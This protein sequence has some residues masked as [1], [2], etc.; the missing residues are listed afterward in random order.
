MAHDHETR[1]CMHSWVHAQTRRGHIHAPSFHEVTRRVVWCPADDHTDQIRALVL[2]AT[3]HDPCFDPI[4]SQHTPSWISVANSM[5]MCLTAAARRTHLVACSCHL[6]MPTNVV[7]IA[8]PYASHHAHGRASSSGVMF[9]PSCP[10][11]GR[12][13]R[14][15]SRGARR[16]CRAPVQRGAS[17]HGW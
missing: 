12:S 17:A 9:M 10:R 3:H 16:P 1:T 15:A 5:S 14:S 8:C 11:A 2:N 13:R 7:A 4:P 6:P